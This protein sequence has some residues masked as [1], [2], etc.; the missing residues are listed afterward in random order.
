MP[1]VAKGT[2]EIELTPGPSEIA[3]AVARFDFDK[4]F[5]GD[6]EAEGQ[7][8]MLSCGNP[9]S[10]H[11]GYVAVETVTGQLGDRKGSFALQQFGT[12]NQGEQTL[13]YEI[14]PGSGQAGLEGI[15]GVLHLTIAP[16]GSH[17]YELEYEL[18]AP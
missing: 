16:D 13:H 14:T 10:G 7:G 5:S 11:A 8:L 1:T 4:T 3:G 17:H 12:I 6:L 2:F 18:R 9:T 15:S